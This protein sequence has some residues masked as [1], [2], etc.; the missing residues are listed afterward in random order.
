M[1]LKSKLTAQR[2]RLLQR[3]FCLPVSSWQPRNTENTEMRVTHLVTGT[4]YSYQHY[5]D[6][7][8]WTATVLSVSV[9]TRPTRKL[10][11]EHI[12]PPTPTDIQTPV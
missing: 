6:D 3:P 8:S 7:A 11:A 10:S 12:P 1:V 2:I 9:V 4:A 5:E